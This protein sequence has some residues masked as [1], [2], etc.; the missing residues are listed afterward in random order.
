MS[1]MI[2]KI[3]GSNGNWTTIRDGQVI[4]SPFNLN[5][6]PES[7]EWSILAGA[8]QNQGAVIYSS[9]WTGWVPVAHCGSSGDPGT[10][11]F[12]INN[13]QITGTVVQG[14]TPRTCASSFES[15]VR[16]IHTCRQWASWRIPAEQFQM[17][18]RIVC[19]CLLSI[20]VFATF[21][22]QGNPHQNQSSGSFTTYKHCPSEPSTNCHSKKRVYSCVVNKRKNREKSLELSSR[23]S[24]SA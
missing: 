12:R 8:Y 14:P 1:I 3:V 9:L 21:R 15:A 20:T 13:L 19:S 24:F 7:N 6:Q 4:I 17:L 5:P 2:H 11:S 22:Y 10:S 16:Q 18:E 23:N